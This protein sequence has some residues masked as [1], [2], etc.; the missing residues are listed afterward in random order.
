MAKKQANVEKKRH[1]KRL[2][3]V[4]KGLDRAKI[5]S[6]EE[7]VAFVKDNASAKF[8]ETVEIAVTLGIDTKKSD[9]QVRGMVVLPHGNGKTVRVAVFAKGA[10]ADEAK[11]AGADIV[12]E[13]DLMEQIK[14]G[15]MDFERC[16]ATP[17]MMPI[18]GR[19]GQILGPKG[20]MPNPKLGT[21]TM[22]VANAVKNAKG[23]SVEYRA[24]KAGIVHVG[25]G[26][27]SFGADQILENIKTV[28]DALVKA[29]PQASKG[30][31]IK[32]FSVSSTMGAGLKVDV[33][34][35]AK[36]GK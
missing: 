20:M 8:D 31:Y 16:I 30:V 9:Q 36:A 21:V 35:L 32:A 2:H 14:K 19:L 22:D 23:G 17:D 1:S 29:K 5:W 26:K 13:E 10:K 25:V 4:K 12:G 7:A 11:A 15:N 27:A 6:L 18:V 24:E 34:A 33:D 3:E 28:Y